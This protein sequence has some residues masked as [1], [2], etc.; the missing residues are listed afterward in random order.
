MADGSL[1][2]IGQVG[3]HLSGG[4]GG[5]QAF[6]EELRGCLVVCPT[7]CCLLCHH[8]VGVIL[9]FILDS[10]RIHDAAQLLHEDIDRTTVEYQ[11]MHIHQQIGLLL[12][13][14]NLKTIER[15]VAE[16]ERSYK[17]VLVLSQFLLAH[18]LY[19]YLHSLFQVNG[20]HNSFF[21]V[22]KMNG[23]L[24]MLLHKGLDGL[25]QSSGVSI[26]REGN[27]VGDV[28]ERCLRIFHAV[29]IDSSL[30]ITQWNR[31]ERRDMGGGCCGF[32]LF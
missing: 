12:G 17:V 16:V 28:I 8:I 5:R 14:H 23:H 25:C 4:L 21:S 30:G 10:L 32:L 20:L 27:L 19:R 1:G 11:V 22:S 6:L 24:R 18:L 29:E 7:F 2:G 3:T 15:T 26:L 31:G 9:V 13:S